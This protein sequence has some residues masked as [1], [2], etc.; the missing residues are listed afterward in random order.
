[1]NCDECLDIMFEA[2]PAALAGG[3]EGA[4]AEHLRS[5]LAC[6]EMAASIVRDTRTLAGV[7][8][9]RRLAWR[10][11]AAVLGLAAAGL[12]LAIGLRDRGP[13]PRQAVTGESQRVGPPVAIIPQPDSSTSLAAA[14]TVRLPTRPASAM[15]RAPRPTRRPIDA[16]AYQPASFVATPIRVASLINE[17]GTSESSPT[18]SVRPAAG[19]RAAVFSTQ[20]PGVTIVWL[21]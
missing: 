4:L 3:G 5:C 18:V 6:R 8:E 10:R 7:V 20:T 11:P 16:V 1:M 19:R 15:V 14:S 12:V 17:P 13:A 21:Y 9:R 2:E